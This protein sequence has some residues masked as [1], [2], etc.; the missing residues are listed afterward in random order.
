MEHGQFWYV[1]LGFCSFVMVSE[2]FGVLLFNYSHSFY[3]RGIAF[4]PEW[5]LFLKLFSFLVHFAWLQFGSLYS[6]SSAKLEPGQFWGWI[7]GICSFV[8]VSEWN[9]IYYLIIRILLVVVWVMWGGGSVCWMFLVN[10]WCFVGVCC[11]Y[12]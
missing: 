11:L 2:G 12:K 5:V 3:G 6:K 9:G 7:W 8:M 4:R 10:M 1:F